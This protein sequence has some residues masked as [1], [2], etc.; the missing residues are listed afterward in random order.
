MPA[1]TS[2][3]GQYTGC[4][5]RY[6]AVSPATDE[7]LDSIAGQTSLAIFDI[8]NAVVNDTARSQA[9]TPLPQQ[10]SSNALLSVWTK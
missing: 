3:C 8:T 9:I 7:L 1:C 6:I 5:T 10:G 4:D 2:D